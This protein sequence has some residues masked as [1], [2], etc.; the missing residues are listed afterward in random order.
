MKLQIKKLFQIGKLEILME[1]ILNRFQKFYL[2][3]INEKK[4]LRIKMKEK[5]INELKK[6]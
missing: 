6:Y 2:Y 5:L 1:V 4:I 3:E